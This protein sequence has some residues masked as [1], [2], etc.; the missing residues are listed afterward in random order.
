MPAPLNLKGMTFGILKAVK[1]VRTEGKNRLWLCQ[2]KCGGEKLVSSMRL[3]NGHTKSCGCLRNVSSLVGK[4][5][6]RLIVVQQHENV[7]SNGSRKWI[8]VCD[9]GSTHVSN[10]RDLRSGHTKSCGCIRNIDIL[11][12]FFRFV[13]KKPSGC[14]EWTG[15]KDKDGYG[16][17]SLNGDMR[18]HRASYVL[19]IGK[20][21]NGL[22]VCH[23]CD[24]PS[25]VN[26]EHLWQGTPKDNITDMYKKKRHPFS[27]L[28]KKNEKIKA[29]TYENS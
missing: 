13:Q 4:K 11:D 15:S 29:F 9:C 17:F 1:F 12:R 20:L 19:F 3:R 18:A 16:K 24:N 8:C 7:T 25:C 5:F 27:L 10:T 22:F 26:P 6:G 21:K 28:N 14:W 23:S 2:C